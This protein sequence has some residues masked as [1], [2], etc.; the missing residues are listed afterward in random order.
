M[1]KGQEVC[2]IVDDMKLG[3]TEVGDIIVN[4]NGRPFVMSVTY[5]ARLATG[6]SMQIER[7]QAEQAP[8]IF[9]PH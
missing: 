4:F 1:E 8:E 3:R 7:A 2:E 9:V 5:A 6:L